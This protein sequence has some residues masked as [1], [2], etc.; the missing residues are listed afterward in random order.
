[1][2]EVQN[3]LQKVNTQTLD[4]DDLVILEAEDKKHKERMSLLSQK[5]VFNTM[6]IPINYRDKTFNNFNDCHTA[7]KVKKIIE[8]G[9]SL[10]LSGSPGLGKTHLAIASIIYKKDR[11]DNKRPLFLSSP[12]LFVELKDRIDNKVTEKSIIDK[13]INTPLLVIDD[14][15]VEKHTESSIV[16]FYSILNG[17]KMRNLQTIITTELNI[18][19]IGQVY[20]DRISSRLCEMGEYIELKGSDYRLKIQ[21]DRGL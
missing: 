14:L 13:Y 12:E 21:R 9:L 5:C 10:V 11:F 17:R 1:M 8:V 7:H 6:N 19:E 2:E 15:G 4:E 20:G 18:E 16:T 3:L